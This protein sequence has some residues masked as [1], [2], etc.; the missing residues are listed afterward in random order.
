VGKRHQEN[1]LLYHHTIFSQSP[2]DQSDKPRD[3]FWRGLER[4]VNTD[5]S[6]EAYL[7][8]SKSWATFWPITIEDENHSNIAWNSDA[9][10]LFIHYRNILRALWAREFPFV[11]RSRAAR[12]NSTNGTFVNQL[13]GTVAPDAQIKRAFGRSLKVA[14]TSFWPEWGAGVVRFISYNDFQRAVWLL[15]QESWR[16]KLCSVCGLY[17]IASKPAQGHC[18]TICSNQ[19]H[20]SS[21]LRW[22]KEKGAAGRKKK[23]ARNKKRARK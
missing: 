10:I 19:A 2:N 13:F 20:R 14:I 1:P 16:A 7:A 5:D 21:S 18:S 4:F 15:F 6:V 11:D 9:H 22:W 8:L 23:Q 3:W 12:A 17:F